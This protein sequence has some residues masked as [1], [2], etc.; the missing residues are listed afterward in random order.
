[1]MV[2]NHLFH[3]LRFLHSENTD[4]HP[5]RDDPHYDKLWKIKKKNIFD[6][7]NNKFCEKYS[8]PK[9]L[10]VDEVIVLYRGG[11]I[12]WQYIPKKHNRF[13]IKIYKLCKLSGLGLYL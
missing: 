1:M 12:V 10:A 2:H 4:D 7:P 6:A 3:I 8:P 5:N 11:V 13:G 9:H